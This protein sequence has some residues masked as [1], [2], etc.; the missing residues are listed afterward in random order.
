MRTTSFYKVDASN[1]NS[2]T[3]QEKQD[4]VK[5]DTSSQ[6]VDIF[7]YLCLVAER[8]LKSWVSKRLW[9]QE[10]LDLV[11]VWMEDCQ[12]ERGERDLRDKDRDG[13]LIWWEDTVASEIL[14]KELNAPLAYISFCDLNHSRQHY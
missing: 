14:G 13:G 9:E 3:T 7:M 2:G 10:G 6:K 1:Q 5:I 11:R 8:L 4:V 12:E